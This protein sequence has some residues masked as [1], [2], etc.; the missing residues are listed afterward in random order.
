MKLLKLG[1]A[2]A[3]YKSLNSVACT[4]H[5]TLVGSVGCVAGKVVGVEGGNDVVAE[6]FINGS[7]DR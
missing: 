4:A 5:G 2:E 1:E 3:V 7:E 6:V